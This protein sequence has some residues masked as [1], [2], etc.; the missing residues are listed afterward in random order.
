VE[1]RGSRRE[2]KIERERERIEEPKEKDGRR[3][4]NVERE[5]GGH[6]SGLP[7]RPGAPFLYVGDEKAQL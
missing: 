1:G 6:R 2:R 5:R 4:R 7:P 3:G